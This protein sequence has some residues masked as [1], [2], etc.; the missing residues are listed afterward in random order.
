ML[1]Q[2]VGRSRHGNL[3]SSLTWTG[4]LQGTTRNKR[5]GARRSHG[6]IAQLNV[7]H[8]RSVYL[9]FSLRG[10][11]FDPSLGSTKAVVA[12]YLPFTIKIS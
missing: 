6:G 7:H 9:Q 1:R 3:H 2:L 5:R 8:P 11:D 12:Q 4:L 10:W